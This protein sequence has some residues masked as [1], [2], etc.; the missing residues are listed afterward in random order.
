MIQKIY[1]HRPIVAV[2]K[3]YGELDEV[4]NRV[5]SEAANGKFD[6]MDKPAAP[7]RQ[8]A[9]VYAINIT[10]PN[11]LELI[12]VYS[13]YSPKVSLRRILYWFVENEI[14]NE[15]DWEIV[16]NYVDKSQKIFTN[17]L[18]IIVDELEK[19]TRY[20][21]NEMTIATLM[22]I[23]DEVKSVERLENKLNGK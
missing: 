20:T 22:H 15:L 6:I 19:A 1:L 16:N 8:G 14:Y 17:K 18:N 13:I 21:Q 7:P 2:L 5:L 11:Y 3:C 23:C 9:G 10:E 4:I 12:K